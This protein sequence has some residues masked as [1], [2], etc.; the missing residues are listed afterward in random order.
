M[1]AKKA[2]KARK[3]APDAAPVVA[4]TASRAK[5]RK[6]RK[7]APG[8][9]EN[10]R[11][12]LSALDD[13]APQLRVPA[14]PVAQAFIPVRTVT[15]LTSEAEIKKAFGLPVTMGAPE[16]V[17]T[18][19]DDA[20]G[21]AGGF[22]M[23]QKSLTQHAEELGQYPVTSFIG[24]GALQQI[25]QNGMIRACVQTVA[26][27]TTR[28]W[29]E[30]RGGDDTPAQVLESL[31][32]AAETKYNLQ[33]VFHDASIM[34]G[35]MGGA[36]IFIDTGDDEDLTLPLA[37]NEKSAE[38]QKGTPLRFVV[39]DPANVTPGE[40]NASDPLKADYMKPRRWW[41]LGKQV[42]ASRLIPL[43]DNPAPTLLKPSYNFLGIPQAQILWDYV[44]HWNQCRVY[45]ADL[46][47]KVSLL[48]FQTD[49]NAIFNEPDGV[50]MFDVRMQALQ[51]YRD[52]NSVFVCNSEQESV[53]NVQTSLAGCTDVVR[54]CLEMIAA[55][56][57]TPAVKLLGISPSGFNATGESDITN[58]YDHVRSR[59]ELRRPA[60]TKCL[61]AIQLAETGR[62]D[63]SITFDWRELSDDNESTQA[64]TASAR[65]GV[66]TTLLQN[67]VISAEEARQAVKADRSMR[68][69]FLS[70]EPPEVE[71][72]E[73]LG[74]LFPEYA[75]PERE[76]AAVNGPD[77][78][79]QVL[80]ELLNASGA[81]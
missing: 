22:S 29:I 74:G 38:V 11:R 53:S 7:S 26:D 8:T 19:M 13:V 39:V 80:A 64:A 55:I 2:R 20:F 25:A 49:T 48:V 15:A 77:E 34:V 43:V 54:Q 12:Q 46:L 44:L 78:G 57:R 42:H 67:Q 47:R 66:V 1:K 50:R 72:E 24:Y 56:N 33:K 58:Y 40:Y 65:T 41:V 10:I 21:A 3:A 71:S 70:D 35:F 28:K 59:Q 30:L 81:G 18:A 4:E 76:P 6:R 79:R 62:I 14:Q 61:K 51:R 63:P 23:I 73:M 27:D 31:A 68:M 36:F 5:V 69:D 37:L 16:E 32:D 17:R 9:A 60:L 52:N 45:T 75:P